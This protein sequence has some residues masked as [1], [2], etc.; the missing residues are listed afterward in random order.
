MPSPA[1]PLSRARGPVPA[2]RRRFQPNQTSAPST[3]DRLSFAV[4]LAA[5]HVGGRRLARVTRSWLLSCRRSLLPACQRD[6][7]LSHVSSESPPLVGTRMDT[8]SANVSQ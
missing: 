8:I 2:L 3:N 1:L 7:S 5:F 6:V 4:G